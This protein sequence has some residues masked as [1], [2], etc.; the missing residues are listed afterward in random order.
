MDRYEVK[1]TFVEPILGAVP[2]DMDI[3]E[4][5]VQGKAA[6]MGIELTDGQLAEELETIEQVEEKG[7]TGF[8][9][10]DGRPV[11]YDYVVKGF[12]KDA[13]GMLRRA[14]RTKSSKLTA[15]KKVIDGLVFV[16]PRRI[17]LVLPEGEEMGTLERP[18]RGQTAQGERVALARSDT[19]PAGTTMEFAVSV[20]GQVSQELL[21]EWLDYGEY[22]GL[23]QWRN[24]SWGTFEYGMVKRASLR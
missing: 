4:T 7:W 19:C 24:A 3:Y 2:K 15:Y 11:L 8:H 17:P 12:F 18:L 13:C 23:G 22:R 16:K 1:L 14:D 20:M 6:E 10:L 9:M 21:R 5:Y